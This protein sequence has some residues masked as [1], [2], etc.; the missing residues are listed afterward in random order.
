MFSSS[1]KA[2]RKAVE[3]TG[4]ELLKGQ[5]SHVLRHTFASYFMMNGGNILVLQRIL[6]HASIVDTMKYSHFA[7]EH[8]EDAVRLN[9]MN[10]LTS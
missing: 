4:F 6:E 7:P 3:R 8:L 9:P 10:G 5:M 2:F 1:T